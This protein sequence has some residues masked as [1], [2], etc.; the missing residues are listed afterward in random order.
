MAQNRVQKP[1]AKLASIGVRI[2]AFITDLFLIGMPVFYLTTYVFLDGK[3]DFLHNQIAIFGA[4]FSIGLILC[5]FFAKK[6]QS[7]GY[8]SQKIY[9]VN[10]KNGKKMSFF[11][12]VLRY[13]CFLIAG[14]S[15]IGLLLCFF[16]KDGLNF[17]DIVTNSAAVSKA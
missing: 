14:F 6:A 5:I 16:R 7:P 4:N 2:K 9:L 11:H 15:I 12:I 1:K 8:R 10:L 13:F 17:H 3:S